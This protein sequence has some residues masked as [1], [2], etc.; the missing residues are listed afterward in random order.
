MGKP[1]SGILE[2]HFMWLGNYDE[3]RSVTAQINATKQI[4][5]KYCKASFG[6]QSQVCNIEN[7]G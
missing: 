2:A 4:K 6:Q 5:G 3:C 7:I 1:P